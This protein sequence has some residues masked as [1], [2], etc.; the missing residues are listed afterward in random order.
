MKNPDP[1]AIVSAALN[2]V[3]ALETEI[4]QLKELSDRSA[5]E[6]AAL[7]CSVDLSDSKGLAEVAR[8][9]TLTALVPRRLAVRAEELVAAHAGLLE[10][11]HD[12]VSNG[13]GPRCQALAGRIKGKLSPELSRHFRDASALD[14]AINSSSL[15]IE[16]NG[17][18]SVAV[19]R[20]PSPEQM[21]N[22]A[23]SLVQAWENLGKFEKE[24]L[25]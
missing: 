23:R 10:A 1:S 14:S 7:E 24:N 20:E 21:K 15:A 25:N 12:F 5:S 17:I 3:S 18:Q 2:K 8:L 19:K 9:Q 16:L 4:P 22:Y 13:L 6:L 11:C